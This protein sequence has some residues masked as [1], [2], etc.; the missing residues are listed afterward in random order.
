MDEHTRGR[1]PVR[2]LSDLANEADAKRAR[3]DE[4]RN[5]LAAEG[6]L[7][8]SPLLHAFPVKDSG[9]FLPAGASFVPSHISR[10][11]TTLNLF[12]A[13]LPP[14]MAQRVVDRLQP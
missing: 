3:K 8:I 7:P 9:Q 4:K 6:F 14:A 10:H 2:R 13:F 5:R 1:K 11:A 12:H